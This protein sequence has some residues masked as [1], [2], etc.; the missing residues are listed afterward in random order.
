MPLAKVTEWSLKLSIKE[1]LREAGRG[2]VA[3]LE[4]P[5]LLVEDQCEVF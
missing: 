4:L 1:H 5:H 2:H 3:R